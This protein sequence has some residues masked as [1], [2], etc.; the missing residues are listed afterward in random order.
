VELDDLHQRF[1]W[2]HLQHHDMPCS[3]CNG[4][5][6]DEDGCSCEYCEGTATQRW[7]SFYVQDQGE[8]DFCLKKEVPIAEMY[9]AA[10]TDKT[11]VC[12]PCYLKH[13]KEAQCC[14]LWKEAEEAFGI[15][16]PKEGST[17][18][19]PKDPQGDHEDP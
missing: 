5:G 11:W 7:G 2:G 15:D 4:I 12:L 6:R 19:V 8:C 10:D 18:L 3:D 14:E 17:E 1:G 13:H 9:E 16:G